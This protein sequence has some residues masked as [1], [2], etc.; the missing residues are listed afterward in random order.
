MRQHLINSNFAAPLDSGWQR[1]TRNYDGR[2]ELLSL[3]DGGVSVRK[4]MCGWARLVQVVALP[5]Q[6]VTF[7][8]RA[9]FAAQS[10]RPDYHASAAVVLGWLSD[11]GRE[12]GETR[13]QLRSPAIAVV[14][15]AT[16]Q[17]IRVEEPGAWLD[18]EL[19]VAEA[20]RSGLPGIK[21]DDVRAVRISYEAF[22]SGTG[23]C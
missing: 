2:A 6:R 15:S 10:S 8:T 23:G 20:L 16:K 17:V 7:H 1:D 4:S 14:S 11:D 9:R 19:D 5:D 12:L 22:G 21:P 3:P 18:L 13:W